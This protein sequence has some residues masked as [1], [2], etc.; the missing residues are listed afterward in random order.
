MSLAVREVGSKG[1]RRVGKQFGCVAWPV[2]FAVGDENGFP[3][4]TQCIFWS[5]CDHKD[6]RTGVFSE[7]Q[8]EIEHLGLKP[9]TEGSEW[10]VKQHKGASAQQS[11]RQNDPTLLTTLTIPLV[12]GCLV[13]LALPVKDWSRPGLSPVT[14]GAA[15]A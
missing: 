8:D 1:V 11:P 12:C 4:K 6:S 3:S 2:S 10:F 15:T 7:C 13:V 9:W 14:T 5:M